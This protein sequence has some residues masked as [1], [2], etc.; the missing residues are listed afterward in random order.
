MGGLVNHRK[1]IHPS[2]A[3]FSQRV[4]VYY[5]L[6]PG[7]VL[8]E[9][10]RTPGGDPML[11]LTDFGLARLL[12]S[13]PS[14]STAARP[15]GTPPYMAPELIEARPDAAGPP[16]ELFGLGATLFELLIGRPPH[17]AETP[18]K[19]MQ[20]VLATPPDSLRKPRPEIPRDLEAV[21]LRCLEK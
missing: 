6:K 9:T 18:L 20:A 16:A 10:P 21:C 5:D 17:Q 2:G 4:L 19:L 3:R 1:A 11:R 12:D 14:A 7:N 13:A 8:V 15:M